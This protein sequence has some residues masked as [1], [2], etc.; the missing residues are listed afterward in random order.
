MCPKP[1][2][3]FQSCHQPFENDSTNTIHCWFTGGRPSL[4]LMSLHPRLDSC[5]E[6]RSPENPAFSILSQKR[7]GNDVIM[8]YCQKKSCFVLQK[9]RLGPGLLHCN[10]GRKNASSCF[11]DPNLKSTPRLVFNFLRSLRWLTFAL[12]TAATWGPVCKSW[13]NTFDTTYKLIWRPHMPNDPK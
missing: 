1:H 8:K 4:E 9:K 5:D 11:L 3:E 2:V 7:K 13:I 6:N 10:N 12:V